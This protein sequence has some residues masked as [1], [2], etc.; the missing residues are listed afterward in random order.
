[1]FGYVTFNVKHYI[2]SQTFYK[3]KPG[4]YLRR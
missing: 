3:K 4:E 1:M 2:L